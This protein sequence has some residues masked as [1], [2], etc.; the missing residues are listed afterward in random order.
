MKYLTLLI[1]LALT[2]CG[3]PPPRQEYKCIGDML[4]YIERASK[5][6]AIVPVK[7]AD[8]SDVICDEKSKEIL[9]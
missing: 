5:S 9:K 2:A 8:G 7:R 3:S 4:Y 6:V 1:V